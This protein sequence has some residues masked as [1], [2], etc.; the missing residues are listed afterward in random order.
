MLGLRSHCRQTWRI[1]VVHHDVDPT[2]GVVNYGWSHVIQWENEMNFPFQLFVLECYYLCELSS[3]LPR[4]RN[5]KNLQSKW[6]HDDRRETSDS[7][8]LDIRGLININTASRSPWL[9]LYNLAV[10]SQWWY[11]SDDDDDDDVQSPSSSTDLD[12]DEVL[13]I[14]KCQVTM[15]RISVQE[16]SLTIVYLAGIQSLKEWSA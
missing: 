8:S 3:I 5:N 15:T 10:L 6:G 16:V 11:T 9:I 4:T 2:L 1:L 13:F 14:Q 7:T 12:D